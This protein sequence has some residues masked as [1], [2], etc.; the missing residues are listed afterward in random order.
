VNWKRLQLPGDQLAAARL[1]CHH[2]VQLN[3]RLARGFVTA[4]PDDS[5]TSLSWSASSRA[6]AGQFVDSFRLALR[7]ADFTMLLESG[8]GEQISA[9]PLDE[10]TFQEATDWLADFLRSSG[11]DPA[12]L[13]DP[14]HFELEDHPLLHGDR[15]RFSG[16][17]P[18]FQELA[19]WY[20]NAAACLESLSSPVRC[21]PHH[22]DI[23]TQIVTGERSMGVG[24][25]PGDASYAQPYYYV[26]PWPYPDASRLPA[27]PAG[28]WHTQDWVGAVLPASEILR[29]EDQSGLVR[30]FLE[31][32]VETLRGL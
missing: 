4:Q 5:H 17:E 8:S 21:W 19:A 1:Q 9:F 10:R 29:H 7:I 20:A 15:F 26:T 25:S 3:T 14:I 11:I 32:A 13:A 6:L 30:D 28:H 27:L 18:V 2:A 12:P 24:M 31:A 23:A 22:F 16:S